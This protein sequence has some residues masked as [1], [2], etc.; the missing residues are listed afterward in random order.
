MAI[1]D[2]SSIVANAR[3]K[4]KQG[5]TN[6]SSTPSK[7]KDYSSIVKKQILN[8]TINFD[9]F[10][11][12]LN[13]LGTTIQGIYD[14]WQTEETMKNTRS[15]IEA[16][17]NR[18]SAYQEYRN[19]FG[20]KESADLTDVSNSY[21][22][23]LDEWDDLASHYGQYKS[24]DDYKTALDTQEKMKTDDLTVVQ[25]EIDDLEGKLKKAEDIY[26]NLHYGATTRANAQ[27]IANKNKKYEKE[28]QDYLSQYGYKNI[29]EL[30]GLVSNKK[31]YK[32]EAQKV[33]DKIALDKK[34]SE[35]SVSKEGKLGWEKW[36]EYDEQRKA[37]SPS[38]F[39][40][41][42]IR[43]FTTSSDSPFGTTLNNVVYDKRKDTSYQEPQDDWTQEEKNIWGAYFYEGG[44]ESAAEY[45]A[46]LNNEK[47]T[48]K[49][50]KTKNKVSESATSGFW[51]GAGH[52]AGAV[53]TSPFAL[54]DYL[55]DITDFAA[56]RNTIVEE[57]VLTP[58]EYSSTV[59]GAISEDWN[60]WS[61]TLPENIPIIGGK[62]AGDIYSLGISTVESMASRMLGP[63][64]TAINYF[65]QGAAG[66][67]DDAVSRGASPREAI[68]YGTISGAAEAVSEYIGAEKLLNLGSAKT[69]KTFFG[70]AFKNA[71]AEGLEGGFSSVIDKIADAWVLGD[72]SAYNEKI[73]QYRLS[74]MSESEAVTKAF[75]KTAEEV[76]FDSLSEMAAGFLQ[77]APQIAKNTHQEKKIGTSVKNNNATGDLLNTVSLT[78][79]ESEAYKLYTELANAGVSA[80]NI[81]DGQ[82]GELFAKTY[83]DAVDTLRDSSSTS[84]QKAAAKKTLSDLN[85]YSQKTSVKDLGKKVIKTL[86][87]S[88][89]ADSIISEGLESGKDT[90]SY[91]LATEYKAKVE[92]G[93]KLS[94]DE[95][96]NLVDANQKAY[97]EEV[98]ADAEKRLAELGEN[99]ESGKVAEIIAKKSVGEQLSSSEVETLKNSEY[100]N[101]V[102]NELN[103]E[104]LV[105]YTKSMDKEDAKLFLST[106]DG[107]TD[108][109]AFKN[110]FNLVTNYTQNKFT[111][112]YILEHRGVLTPKQVG[113]IYKQKITLTNY[114]QQKAIEELK[115]KHKEKPFVY[116]KFDDSV[117]N[118]GNTKVEGKVNW[119][120]LGSDQKHAIELIG[121]LA[122]E[123]GMDVELITDGLERGI[124]GA[125]EIRGN[126]III[127]V[128]AGMSV[129]NGLFENL[130]LPTFS[131]E[132]THW[133]K[134]KVP[135]LYRKYDEYVFKTLTANGKSEADILAAR[136]NKLEKAHPNETFTDEEVRDEVIARASEDMFGKSEVVREF[137][138]TLSNDEK[139]RFVDK[140]KEIFQKLKAWFERYVAN[141]LS[142]ADEARAIR[143]NI[144]RIDG[145]IKLWDEMLVASIESNQAL[146]NEG[147]TGEE[148]AK[149]LGKDTSDGK[150]QEMARNTNIAFYTET[151]Y[152]N[153]GWVRHNDVLTS[154]EY[155]TLIS[156]YADYKHNKDV[157]PTTR[158]GE[159]V[160]FSF[161][162]PDV[163]MYVKGTIKSPQITKVITID[164]ELPLITQE[165]IQKEILSNERK[166]ISF[167]Y[168]TVTSFF[169]EGCLNINKKRNFPSFE[170][171][172]RGR[173]GKFGEKD[174][175]LDR[176][177]Q[178]GTRGSEESQT[179]DKSERL[180]LSDR[181]S[182]YMDA[183]NNRDMETAQRLVDE[184]ARENG[185]RIKGHHG[186]DVRFTI[187][188]REKTSTS[189]DFGQGFYFSSSEFE[190][191][192]YQKDDAFGDTYNK[193][194]GIAY[195]NALERIRDMGEDA[196]DDAL[197]TK[198]YNEEFDKELK[199]RTDEGAV[200]NAYLKMENPFIVS[201][202]KWITEEEAI[203]IAK[204]TMYADDVPD[205]IAMS[206]WVHS[207][208]AYAKQNDGKV[209]T[210]HFANNMGHAINLTNAL[211]HQGKYDGILDYSIR[212]KFGS[213][214]DYHAIALYS[215]KIKDSAPI[216][217]DDNG[218]VIPLSERFNAAND[219][220]RYS[221]RDSE[222]NTLSKEQ[223][224]FFKDSKVRDED[225][226]LLVCYH[227]TDA[228][229]NSFSNIQTEPGYWFTEEKEYAASHGD[230]ILEV[231]LDIR[232]PFDIDNP[233][234]TDIHYEHFFEGQGFDEKLIL[235][236]KFKDYLVE[237]G[238][239]GM[240]WEHS[241]NKTII[242]FNSNQAKLTTNTNPTSNPDIRYSDRDN[243]SVYDTLGQT[244]K[245][246]KENEQLKEDV[247]RLKERLKLERQV[248]HGNYFNENQLDAVAGH[249]RNIVGSTIDKKELISLLKDVY[250]YI[251]HSPDLNWHDMFA[252][253]YDIAKALI[254]ESKPLTVKNEYYETLLNDIRSTEISVNE[255]QIQE[256][257]YQ[258]GN[259]W[260]NAFFNKVKITKGAFSLDDQWD[261]WAGR[262]PNQFEAGLSDASQLV[263]LYRIYN[264]AKEASEEIME[265]D[266]EER[267]RHIAR[268]VYNQFWN[269]SPIR[270][271]ADKYD[272][273]IKLLNFKHR[274]AM[275]EFRDSYE[276]KL[277]TQ[278]NMDKARYSELTKKIRERKDKEIAE[279][280]KLSKERMDA[281]K[282]NAERKTMIQSITGDA[283]TLNKWLTTN[284]K[285]YRIH[286]AMKGPVIKLL[287]AIDFSSKQMLN[288]NVPT[289]S[290]V[291]FAQAFAEVKDMLVRAENME[292]GLEE[293]YGH[294]LAESID[295]LVQASYNLVGDN[296]YVL[297]KMSLNELKSL[298]Y[299]V[300]SIKRTV[301][302]LNKFHTIHHRQGAISLANTFMEYGD[303]L[304]KLKKQDGKIAKFLKF[305]NA[306]P[307]YFF[308]RLGEAGAKIF[309]A[310]QDG[311]D[312]LAFNT[313]TVIDYANATYTNKEVREWGKETKS[314]TLLQP[315]G[316]KRTFEMTTAQIMALHCVSKQEDA[317]RHL[318]SSGMTLS[319][320]DK[321]GNV[322]ADYENISLTMNDLAEIVG[323]LTDRQKEVANKL[324]EFMNTVCAEWGNEISMA[325]FAVK[326]FTTPNYFPI[327]V[328][329]TTIPTDNTKE[330]DNASLFRLLNMS[331][332]KSRNKFAEQS[333]EIGDIFDIFAQHSSDMAKYNALALPV[334]DFNKFYTQKGKTEGNKEYGV[335]NTLRNAYGEEAVGYL[336]RFVRDINGSQNVSRDIIGKTFF[337][338][339]KVAAVANN[340]RV[341]LLQPTAYF[342]A[343][344]VMDNKYL[345][346]APLFSIGKLKRS[347][348]KAEK[349]CGIIQWKA[350]GYY[351][352]D[353]SRGI[354]EKIKHSD[355]FKD[356]AT[357]FS[358]KGAEI[359]DKVTF[360][361]LWNAC[362]LEVR[363]TRKDLNVGS[364]EFYQAVSKRLR[365]IVYAT[366]VVDSTMT[367]S[368][369]MRSADTFDKMLTTFGSEPTIA[370]N[371]LMDAA[372]QYSLDKK[373]YGKQEARKK[374]GKKIRKVITAYIVT[375]AVA[376]LVESGFDAFRD[377]DDEEEM[378]IEEFMKIY[379][380]NFAFDLSIGNKLPFV[381]EMYSILQGYSSSR[382]D[383]QWMEYLSSAINTWGKIFSGEG[384]GK[385]D[386]AIK[387]VLRLAS[388]ISGYAFYNIYRDLMATLYKL[389]ILDPED[390]EDLF[391]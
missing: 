247:E 236:N 52:T 183:V 90:E 150:V 65:G 181:D 334:L 379:L 289:R 350:L 155:N 12:D 228:K 131:H 56:G 269:V 126:K 136:R 34:H 383:T 148:I 339:S 127:D 301:T 252:Q 26:S 117:I 282:E 357:E 118:Y 327:K 224:E 119:S 77:S 211:L 129:K 208:K 22:S 100:G 147:I 371:M 173:E 366:Q 384:E 300:K 111:Q 215:N 16:M 166:Q 145:Q 151:Q 95:I 332:T 82:L 72:K 142:G 367:R 354:K 312:K 153:F 49:K 305:R 139:K 102:Y 74:G 209:D 342:K 377:D 108:L 121:Y 326:M 360:G 248:T 175:S 51:A 80:E 10:E 295:M 313:K 304:G 162:Y 338:N 184:V 258:L 24:A 98:K 7:I 113:K 32:D 325:R 4:K 347:I 3:L 259:R 189:N 233:E 363:N 18:I 106:Y 61:G 278:H 172:E 107:S 57:S 130:I 337:K 125:Y 187:F 64:G 372:M 241:G 191:E 265:Y 344:A 297:N 386:K 185:Y 110:S 123:K 141:N 356:K 13:S 207:I 116:G 283:L 319:R 68:M 158:F 38:A 9:T 246:L 378:N 160:I 235:S 176:I 21:K 376:A 214:S 291:S 206:D 195:D 179:I 104:E 99:T 169:G 364:E 83:T 358:L 309:E 329:P 89:S 389:E 198:I 352:T 331:F 167:P 30:R 39:E 275:K 299:L 2:Y 50:N 219:D 385:G 317:L 359:A 216:T 42:V 391:S 134:E 387:D 303:K 47:A 308:K 284:S 307:Y 261:I 140:V 70:K 294:D 271:T 146:K 93:K 288:K 86:Y 103:E 361:V 73:R 192:Q 253:C 201:P 310:F 76:A 46:K 29:D 213:T 152:N 44:Y 375:N 239:D 267:T 156:R 177:K 370:Y 302:Q 6:A 124:N 180:K 234:I 293:L 197:F 274:E 48:A 203:E 171:Y 343:G 79:Q 380:K 105:D 138:D 218:N 286:E 238:F 256:A 164:S 144:D 221:D 200:I 243:V 322:V 251:A 36:I 382:M 54:A 81:T 14:G 114:R 31:F 137:L 17:Q 62:G 196:N 306:T 266:I 264:T 88:E 240:M 285:D 188:N 94:T 244:E 273:Q 41:N 28:L 132:L 78:P 182:A 237:Q 348:E 20:N 287:Q 165:T 55:D 321:K 190:A 257:R 27:E 316:S 227:G 260:R 298:D 311:W 388:N 315:N 328:S 43:G 122:V 199:R 161:D 276:E 333:I 323:T 254:D 163:L 59:K 53:A 368:D 231:Y 5:G 154:A 314:F 355:T 135:E 330:F 66:A 225:G 270:T 60:E 112:D 280:K 67:V 272:K 109:E 220:I 349:Y 320:V 222:G 101:L 71:G 223:Q 45:A 245:L 369:V 292:A 210:H 8:K 37:D 232:N 296:T 277:K 217:Y 87:G 96:A 279:V 212:T 35:M 250:S 324:Q 202:S 255:K 40:E 170:E 186:T 345:I 204:N 336:K 91:K 143:E 194:D 149:K 229:F 23:I 390:I 174:N 263:E 290:D 84:E 362:E 226:N 1:K 242:A 63:V 365:E 133:M 346:K 157:Y 193:I 373:A 25:S 97:K 85:A 230:N 205:D 115:A 128:Y 178:D 159:A 69:V 268:E 249:L 374:N 341:I 381:K 351:D 19:T 11:S 353:I 262:Y 281:Y 335:D 75:W 33:Q 340:L 318:L 168:E 15:S 92:S 58:F 120:S